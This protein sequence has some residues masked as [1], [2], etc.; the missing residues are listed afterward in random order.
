MTRYGREF[1]VGTNRLSMV[2]AVVALGGLLAAGTGLLAEQGA[3]PK[4]KK[5]GGGVALPG[6][7]LSPE[8]AAA[9]APSGFDNE[10]VWSVYDDWEPAV[11]SDPIT[12]NLYQITTRYSGPPACKGCP[13]PVLIFRSSSN[14]GVSYGP[15]RFLVVSKNK[16][17]DPQIQVAMN[18]VIYVAW[19]DNFTPGVRFIKSSDH[20]ANWTAPISFTGKGTKPSWSDKPWLAI[21]K[22]GQNVYIA[23]NA[24]DSYVVSSHDSGNTFSAPVKTNNDTRYW[25]ANGGAVASNGTVYFSEVDFS[26]DYTGPAHVNILKST[27]GGLSFTATV[28]DTSQQMIDCPWSAGCTLGFFG[29]S[30]AL[31]IDGSNKLMIAYNANDVAGAPQQIYVRTSTDGVAWS[32]RQLVSTG[33]AGVNS[34]F[35]ALASAPGAG[36]FRLAYQDDRNG[37]TTAFNTWYRRTTTGGGSW[38]PDVRL[39]NLGSGAPYKTSAGYAFPY[40]DYLE[41]AVDPFGTSHVAWGEGTSY[42]GPGGTWY[43]KGL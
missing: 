34:G 27:N 20:G 15:D 40:G 37:P 13:F 8:A 10:R 9:L 5:P 29:S 7:S 36:D 21:S 6:P 2:A 33:L 30:A 22:D 39:S 4:P 23:F 31:A 11:A 17:N 12:S 41:I 26:Q 32:A 24:S 28:L 16:Q 19:L 3:A 43:T 18:G 14:G 38:T 42:T 35:P 1:S 25:F